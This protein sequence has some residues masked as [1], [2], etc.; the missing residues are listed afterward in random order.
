MTAGRGLCLLGRPSLWIDEAATWSHVTGSWP[1]LFRQAAAGNDCGGFIYGALMKPW[2]AVAG[3]S[4]FAL[5]APG[6]LFA[7][8]L[9]AA[10]FLIGRKLWDVRAGLFA[11]ASLLIF[12][13]VLI[14]TREA[15]AYS[16]EL[17]T[18][19]LA[20][21]G[22]VTSERG[23][24]RAGGWRIAIWGS[25]LVLSHI[26]G[27][28]ALA[29][30][31]AIAIVRAATRQGRSFRSVTEAVLPFAPP[32]VLLAAWLVAS[33]HTIESRVESFWIHTPIAETYLGLWIYLV[34]LLL[35]A[36]VLYRLQPP[37]RSWRWPILIALAVLPLLLGPLAATLAA[38]RGQSFIQPRYFL[39][40]A[41]PAA[42]GLGFVLSRAPRLPAIATVLACI[43]GCQALAIGDGTCSV[44]GPRDLPVR[45]AASYL[46]ERARPKERILVFPGPF[47][48][49]LAYY[50]VTSISAGGQRCRN[51]SQW[52]ARGRSKG[53]SSLWLLYTGCPLEQRLPS[54][55]HVMA[56]ETFGRLHAA[57]LSIGPSDSSSAEISDFVDYELPEEFGNR[58]GRHERPATLEGAKAGRD[59]GDSQPETTD[60]DHH[61]GIDKPT[62]RRELHQPERLSCKQLRLGVD[63]ATS[64]TRKQRAEQ[65]VVDRGQG[66]PDKAVEPLSAKGLDQVA[67]GFLPGLVDASHV[68]GRHLA[69]AVDHREQASPRLLEAT[70]HVPTHHP[71]FDL[72]HGAETWIVPRQLRDDRGGRIVRA[73]ALVGYKDELPVIDNVVQRPTKRVDE[74]TDPVT[75]AVAQNHH[76]ELGQR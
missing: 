51:L 56:T 22:L 68:L 42:L 27:V 13:Q 19:S 43:L 15:R 74:R 49:V 65:K 32:M 11:T 33:R 7:T 59:L 47:H 29:G 17:L 50:G 70:T 26:F 64:Q 61:F 8:A 55:V 31:M 44:R 45:P 36:I 30:L 38:R 53:W 46:E 6:V 54:G 69:I 5:R 25:V 37:P 57:R 18:F 66:L 10:V 1:R 9:G 2:T 14:Y 40:L 23:R 73:A 75:A 35:A 12:P 24:A 3:S 67:T 72:Q 62:V 28:L 16:L 20:L 76:R 4:E 39:P 48:R 60:L 41:V 63:V 21:E 52:I 71:S 58:G 34:P